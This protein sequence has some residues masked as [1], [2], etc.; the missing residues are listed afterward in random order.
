MA[1]GNL[2]EFPVSSGD[3]AAGQDTH[4]LAA[5]LDLPVGSLSADGLRGMAI[6]AHCFTCTKDILAARRISEGL[7]AQGIG[8]LR[9]D[10]TGLGHSGGEF[11]NSGFTGNVRDIVAA[12]RWLEG[13]HRAPDILIGHSLGGAAVLAA[14]AQ[15]PALKGVVTIGAP[16]DPAHV[17]HLFESSREEILAN[18]SA[19]VRIAGRQFKICKSFLDDLDGQKQ[20]DLIAG[21]RKDLLILHAPRDEIVGIDNAS[22]I[23]LAAKHPK[24]FVSLDAAD[25]LLSKPADAEFAAQIISAWATRLLARGNA[26]AATLSDQGL[27]EGVVSVRPA[28]AQTFPHIVR[29]GRHSLRA[30]EPA[31]VGGGDSGFTPY[32][33][34]L[35]GLGACTSMTIRMYAARKG[36]VL[37]DVVVNLRHEKRYVD[38]C[39]TC[40]DKPVKIDV[41]TREIALIGDLDEERRARLMEIADKCPVHRTLEGEIRVAT[42]QAAV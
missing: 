38:D 42:K 22:A 6:F 2:V 13:T 32:D 25:H 27:G 40:A 20:H 11:A 8:V 41:I 1:A 7:A 21:L 16:A 37:D 18:G 17:A 4:R 28:G 3:G 15:L 31:S 12:A 14:A 34:L 19:D 10:F 33:L 35:A 9:F 26:Q 30:D 39:E 24:S 5:R 29:A 36:W 23:F